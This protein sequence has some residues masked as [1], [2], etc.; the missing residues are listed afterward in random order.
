MPEAIKYQ[1]SSI[2][3]A[4]AIVRVATTPVASMADRKNYAFIQHNAS[5]DCS[6]YAAIVANLSSIPETGRFIQLLNADSVWQNGDVIQI[7]PKER[8]IISLYKKAWHANA[9]YV[10]DL[11]NSHCI[12]CPQPPQSEDSIHQENLDRLI[13]C[14]PDDIDNLGITGGEPTLLDDR[15]P[16]LLHRLALKA[17][18][19]EVHILSN[20]RKLRKLKYAK[21]I[22]ACGLKCLSFGIPLYS[23]DPEVHNYIVQAPNAFAE[24]CKGI[25]NLERLGIPVEIR[26]V[27]HKQVIPGL[28][29][30]V[31]WLYFNMPYV[32]HIALMG[33]ENMGYVKKNWDSLWI[34]PKDYQSILFD[35]VQ[36]LHLRG[37]NVSIYNLPLCLLDRRLWQFARDSISDFKVSYADECKACAQQSHCG[38][39]FFYQRNTMPIEP[40]RE[41]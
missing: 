26:I 21:E 20:A 31:R 29:E 36:Y 25:V 13:D 6:H 37:M 22:A 1:L 3:L 19:C 23:S 30:L 41:E 17:P 28:L 40:L 39:L 15:L 38:G 32:S 34:S 2:D 5:D 7:L 18:N 9:L 24:T 33:M 4:P 27:L 11:C 8:R 35:S 10:T 16:K 14:L 12:M